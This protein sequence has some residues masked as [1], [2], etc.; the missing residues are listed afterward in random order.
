MVALWNK[1]LYQVTGYIDKA[2]H[3]IHKSM[4]IGDSNGSEK[5]ITKL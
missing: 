1:T 4:F 3:V 2:T 5:L